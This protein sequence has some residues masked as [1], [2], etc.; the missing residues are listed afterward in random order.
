MG[1]EA[2]TGLLLD[3]FFGAMVDMLVCCVAKYEWKSWFGFTSLTKILCR[4]V[5][6]FL[7][8]SKLRCYHLLVFPFVGLGLE[9]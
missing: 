3:D 6:L 2:L 4:I 8:Y 9:Q 7:S 1:V 5:V